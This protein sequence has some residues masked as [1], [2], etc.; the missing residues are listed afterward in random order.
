KHGNDAQTV[1]TQRGQFTAGRVHPRLARSV[2]K[3][4]ARP[5]TVVRDVDA[6][7]QHRLGRQAVLARLAGLRKIAT[8]HD[9]LRCVRKTDDTDAVGSSRNQT[10]NGRTVVDVWIVVVRC[11]ARLVG[12]K[13][14]RQI[15]AVVGNQVGVRFV[16]TTVDDADQQALARIIIPRVIYIDIVDG[17]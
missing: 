7:G 2:I 3:G 14:P 17:H 11:T 9:E 6:V 10:R 15:V 1:A 12:G 13:V 4:V 8:I 5:Q 16:D